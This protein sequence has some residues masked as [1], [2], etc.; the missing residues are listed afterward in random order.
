MSE[1][2]QYR[3]TAL[4]EM[5]PYVPGEDLTGISV[6]IEDKAEIEAGGGGMI[7]RNADNH[8]DQ[9]YVAKDFFNTNYALDEE[10]NVSEETIELVRNIAD[11]RDIYRHWLDGAVCQYG[12]DGVLELSHF[13]YEY[14]TRCELQF[15]QVKSEDGKCRMLISRLVMQD[16]DEHA[17]LSL[18]EDVTVQDGMLCAVSEDGSVHPLEGPDADSNVDACA[19][20]GITIT[21][22]NDSRWRVFVGPHS[23]QAVCKACNQSPDPEEIRSDMYSSNLLSLICASYD[24]SMQA[25]IDQ[26]G[27]IHFD[28]GIV[29]FADGSSFK[30]DT[31]GLIDYVKAFAAKQDQA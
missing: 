29:T 22:E 9:W 25:I 1:W 10:G 2:K 31:E 30:Q 7:A 4:Q 16:T 5:R 15:D 14:G 8:K 24:T 6:S 21:P 26:I 18:G 20:C 17:S 23:T 28:D 3:K 27:P 11:E 12:T 19:K 13:G